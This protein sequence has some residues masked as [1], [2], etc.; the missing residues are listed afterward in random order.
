[1]RSEAV[2]VICSS[3]WRINF[4]QPISPTMRGLPRWR[5]EFRRKFKRRF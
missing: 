4:A 3:L 2:V 5:W 1:M